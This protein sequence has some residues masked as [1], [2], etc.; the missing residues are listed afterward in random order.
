MH[1]AEST[2]NENKVFKN[3]K[4]TIFKSLLEIEKYKVMKKI[5]ALLIF[6]FLTTGIQA[7]S[8]IGVWERYHTSENGEKLKSIVI[9]SDGYQVI[10]TYV[11]KT[12]EFISA[13]SYYF[14][15]LILFFS[16]GLT[17]S[18]MISYGKSVLIFR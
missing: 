9:F 12:G 2:I 4:C 16:L 14:N 17:Y 1:L 15:H 7:Q 3:A 8:F 18:C 10:T 6:T 13:K 5:I 11:S